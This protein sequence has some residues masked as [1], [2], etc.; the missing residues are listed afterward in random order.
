M[1]TRKIT[2]RQAINE[3]MRLEMRRDPTVILFGEDVAGGATLPHMEGEN[4]EAWGGVL[5]VSAGLAPEFGRK[6][7]L[8]TPI[9]ESAFIGAAVGAASTGLRPIAELMFV[10]FLGVCFDQIFNQGAK[11]RYMFGG[12]AQV[13]MVIRSM[14]GAGVRA[15]A[16]HSECLYSVFAH[17]PGLKTVVP[18]T[19]YDAKGLLS[20]AIRDNDPVI[21][22]EHKVLYDMEGEVP[23]ENYTIP[24]GVAD[25]KRK[26]KDV[27]IVSLGR[28]VHF[29]LE[30]A[31]KLA[32]HGID[33]EVVDLRS[34]SP[35]DEDAVLTSVKKTHRL[36]V[37]DEDTPRCS[38]ATDVVAL[39]AD[40]AFDY[41]DAPCKRITAP[42]TPVPF[43]PTLEDAYVPSVDT[44]VSTVKS[45]R[46]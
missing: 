22:F 17:I 38:L 39:V 13:P 1:A 25:V 28:M 9:S 8:D 30:A 15:A 29:S 6:R 19:P 12:K 40:K 33:V 10:D 37:V 24:L 23:E 2:F 43:S 4:K 42:H 16:Q 27:T 36:V 21:F 46:K 41:L 5:G 44:I 20:S 18:S 45:L 3:A 34:I 7:V 32:A 26:G 14:I 35:I 11:L 31:E